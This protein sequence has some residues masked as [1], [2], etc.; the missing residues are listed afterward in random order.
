MENEVMNNGKGEHSLMR[1]EE[2][3]NKNY[4]K[5]G[6]NSIEEGEF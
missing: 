4:E 1:E 2:K 5:I 3:N 6:K